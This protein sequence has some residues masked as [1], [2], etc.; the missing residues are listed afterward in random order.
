[1]VVEFERVNHFFGKE[2]MQRVYAVGGKL[3]IDKEYM[4]FTAERLRNGADE[5]DVAWA[6]Q[7]YNQN[8]GMSMQ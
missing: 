4:M 3:A 2:I 7:E 6:I 8:K 5:E 1:M